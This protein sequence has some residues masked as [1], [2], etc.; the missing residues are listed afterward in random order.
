MAVTK[1]VHRNRERTMKLISKGENYIMGEL[2]M[3]GEKY[4]E[5]GHVPKSVKN[6]TYRLMNA[7]KTIDER[8]K[9]ADTLDQSELDKKIAE[10]E[11]KD[12]TSS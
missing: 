1:D 7:L 4:K 6:R 9:V 12:L 5:G 2:A 3:W 11:N 10:Y 8:K